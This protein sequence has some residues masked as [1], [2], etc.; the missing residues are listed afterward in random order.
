MNTSTAMAQAQA[1]AI[2]IM[3]AAGLVDGRKVPETQLCSDSKIYFWDTAVTSKAASERQTY[4]IWSLDG[5]YPISYADDRVRT[6][7]ADLRFELY[8]R[9]TKTSARVSEIVAALDT[10]AMDLGWAFEFE[11]PAEYERDTA[12]YHQ[13]FRLNKNL[14]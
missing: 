7:R 3:E 9:W 11:G 14:F 10:Q 2:K 6:R 8:S 13:A 4:L 5:T 12:I 1:E